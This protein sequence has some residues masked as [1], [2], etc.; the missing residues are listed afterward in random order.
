MARIRLLRGA[1][2][3]ALVFAVSGGNALHAQESTASR[4]AAYSLFGVE[5]IYQDWN[6][7]GPATLTMALTYYTDQTLDQHVAANWLKPNYEDKNVSPWQ[8]AEYVNTQLGGNLRLL[9]RQGG[10]L[11][12]LK[13]LIA[14]DFPVVIEEGYDPPGRD[15]GWMGHYL[16]MSGYD[17]NASTFLTQ[18]SYE[19]PNYS[20]TYD[21][22]NEYW[23]HFNRIFLVLYPQEREAEL[24][25]LLGSDADTQQNWANALTE[26]RAEAVANPND[27]FAWFNMGTS[28]VGLGMDAEAAVAYDQARNVGEGLPWR[29]LWYQFGPFEAYLSVGRNQDVIDLAQ[30]N[31]NDG[32]GQYVEE[33]FYY[34]ALARAAMGETDRAILNLDGAISFN[35]N[36]TPARDAKARLQG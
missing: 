12:Q 5:H 18:D 2:L 15:L 36:F 26:A 33:T 14:N 11:E 17:D 6:N 22:I 9:V 4:P 16:L 3:A 25:A 28:F 30:A 13:T 20:Y 8:M 1:A 32:G 27:P 35:P 7:C 23:R 29:M 34:A 10:D 24:M 21:H 19:G 31:L